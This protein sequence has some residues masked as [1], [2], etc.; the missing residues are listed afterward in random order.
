M[1]SIF[2]RGNACPN[3]SWNGTFISFCPGLTT[4]ERLRG[5][6]P[7]GDIEGGRDLPVRDREER[8]SVED[9][10]DRQGAGDQ[11]LM[12][13]YACDETP[14]LMPLP[15]S[16]VAM[17]IFG[18]VGG[19]MV[20]LASL[21]YAAGAM[22]LKHKLPGAPP[23]PVGAQNPLF[24]RP[25]CMALPAA[26]AFGVVFSAAGSSAPSTSAVTSSRRAC[27]STTCSCSSSS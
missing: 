6:D 13:G 2:N 7:E 19:L 24:G 15:K 1:D 9:P 25:T 3:A 16:A 11:G 12:F 22:L 26:L 27:R 18:T 8:R 4:D 23:V 20:L 10:L 21:G 5:D 17:P 14:A